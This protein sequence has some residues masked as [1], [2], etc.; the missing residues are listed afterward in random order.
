MSDGVKS[1]IYPVKDLAAAKARFAA[2]AGQEPPFDTPYYVGFQIGGLDI[3]LDPTG[4]GKGMA[5]PVAYWKVDD[6]RAKLKEL[7]D[8]GAQSVQDATDVGG[9]RTI[10]SVKDPDGNVIGLLQDS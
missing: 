9:G 5:G 6:I 3:G 2:I 4:H 7:I 8:G 10:A 1:I